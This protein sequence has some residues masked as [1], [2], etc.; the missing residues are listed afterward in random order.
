M[1]YLHDFFHLFF[2]ALCEACS[3]ALYTGE[4]LV[5]LRCRAQLPRT[6]FGRHPDNLVA[7]LF[8][9]RVSLERAASAYFFNKG[10]RIQHLLHALKYKNRPDVGVLLGRWMFEEMNQAGFL[11]D[12][13]MLVPVPLHPKKEKKRGY[14]Q[15]AILA[16]GFA[17]SSAIPLEEKALMRAENTGSQTRLS[18]IA[19]W[20]NTQEAFKLANPEA[21][22]GKHVLLMDDVIT[23]GA[24]LEACANVLI[25]E[26]GCRVSVLSVACAFH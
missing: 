5:C 24:T 10:A 2:P 19:R 17:A 21:V 14:N 4:E 13:D 25:Q 15:A 12:V 20:E 22:K 1:A 23:T 7:R 18:R 3:S 26:G 11:E 16:R 6:G 9:G 8:W